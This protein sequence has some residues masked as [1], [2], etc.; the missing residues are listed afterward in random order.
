[1]SKLSL[2]C[3]PFAGA[4]ASYYRSWRSHAAPDIELVPVQ[5]P[6]RERLIEQEP[7]R[8]IREA[9]A[10][11][12]PRLLSSVE[13][14]R[15]ALFGHSSGGVLALALAQ[16]LA[17]RTDV[18]VVRL[19]VSGAPGPGLRR[20]RHATGLPDEAF[21][22]RVEE[23]AGYRHPALDNPEMRE[24]ILPALRADVEMY[25][26][27]LHDPA[28]ELPVPITSLRGQDDDNVT[29]AEAQDWRNV[30]SCGFEFVEMEGGHMYLNQSASEVLRVV[31]Q[32]TAIAA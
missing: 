6:G 17:T 8:S 10:T 3:V 24:L 25:E 2:V 1:M 28:V 27:F 4:G 11:V 30:T 18:E 13:G 19:F 7:V 21:I 16:E 29:L 32:A 14:T 5:L 15:V 9:V 20:A 31:R 22:E 12:L 23:F 26:G